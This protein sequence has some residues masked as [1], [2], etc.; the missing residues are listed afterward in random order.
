MMNQPM[1]TKDQQSSSDITTDRILA[2]IGKLTRI[3]HDAVRELGL[4]K[5]I[6]RA[7]EAVP[8]ARGRLRY[9]AAMAE[10]A[11]ERVLG[12]VD[13]AKPVQ[14]Q[15]QDEAAVL[16]ALWER[17]YAAP[18]GY[19]AAR[20]LLR[21]TRAFLLGVPVEVAATNAQLREIMMAQGFQDLTGQVIRTIMDLIALIEQQLVNV[22]LE[23]IGEDRRDAFAAH[24]AEVDTPDNLLKG[25][26]INAD[27]TAGGM[28]D[29][30][31]VDDLL[32]NLG[33]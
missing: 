28:Q 20:A 15:L 29:Q 2:R 18:I 9:I 26:Q 30:T 31:Q 11:A 16:D 19:D 10:Q 24:A 7:A 17:W 5:N 12:A 8:G 14:D 1:E 22:L 33:F 27:G 21:D 3:L 23:N 6:E 25:P 32:A 4:E 13:V